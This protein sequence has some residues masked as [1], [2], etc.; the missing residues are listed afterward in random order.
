[1]LQTAHK[2]LKVIFGKK[3][4]WDADYATES[5]YIEQLLYCVPKTNTGLCD[6]FSR[7]IQYVF[8]D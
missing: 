2:M 6:I 1:M 8:N 4:T 3:G 5:L 7:S